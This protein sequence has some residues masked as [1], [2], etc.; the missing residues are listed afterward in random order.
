MLKP[1]RLSTVVVTVVFAAGILLSVGCTK[2]ASQDDLQRLEEA[3]RAA[4][5]AEKELDKTKADRKNVERDLA[6]IEAELKT[7]QNELDYVKNNLP[8]TQEME[9]P[10]AVDD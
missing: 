10:E 5:S 7:A 8:E 4:I 6:D 1:R 3:R 2:Y 9:T